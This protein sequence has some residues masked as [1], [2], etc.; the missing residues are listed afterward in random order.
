MT[1][2][3]SIPLGL[4]PEIKAISPKGTELGSNENPRMK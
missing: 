3:S 2:G 1:R 4:V